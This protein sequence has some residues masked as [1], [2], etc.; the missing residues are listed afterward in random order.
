VKYPKEC[1]LFSFLDFDGELRLVEGTWPCLD[2]SRLFEFRY[3]EGAPTRVREYCPNDIDALAALDA[4]MP[5]TPAAK[6]ML[7]VARAARPTS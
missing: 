6:E 3:V 7:A 1:P 5:L 2:A 4:L